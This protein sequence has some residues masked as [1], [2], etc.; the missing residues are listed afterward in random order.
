MEK[1]KKK[2]KKEKKKKTKKKKEEEGGG[3]GG[4]RRR[5]RR[6]PTFLASHINFAFRW[7]TH[8][9]LTPEIGKRNKI[10]I[11]KDT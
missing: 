1:I 11:N 4:R 2:K 3:G 6:H 8:P 7:H 9:C 5:R 10:N